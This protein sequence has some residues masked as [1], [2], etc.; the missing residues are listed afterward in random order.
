MSEVSDLVRL[1]G[2]NKYKELSKKIPTAFEQ[3]IQ[4]DY[5]VYLLEKTENEILEFYSE[6]IN[7]R[8]IWSLPKII[9]CVM[10]LTTHIHSLLIKLVER[11]ETN[12]Q[13]ID[14]LRK[15]KLHNLIIFCAAKYNIP[16]DYFLQMMKLKHFRNMLAHDFDS[17]LET[18][19][20]QA[21]N[22]IAEGQVLI[23]FLTQLLRFHEESKRV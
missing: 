3:D 8:K 18:S 6:H 16:D 17:S 22:P 12:L 4:I 2:K 23:I 7:S 20:Q 5:S 1:I 21:I 10:I 15:F 19:F 14:T 13:I 9:G 11:R